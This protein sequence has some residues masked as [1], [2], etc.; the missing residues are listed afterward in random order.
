MEGVAAGASPGG[1]AA[2][3]DFAV[4]AAGDAKAEFVVVEAGVVGGEY[5]KGVAAVLELTEQAGYSSTS[6]KPVASEKAKARSAT[7]AN[8]PA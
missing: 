2:D 3:N 5:G 8:S 4:R 6:V 1:A 7:V